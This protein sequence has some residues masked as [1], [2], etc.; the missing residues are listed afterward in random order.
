VGLARYLAFYNHERPHQA[1]KYQTPAKV[2]FHL[3]ASQC[4]ML[5]EPVS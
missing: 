4:G 1:L 3:L 5:A 2:T